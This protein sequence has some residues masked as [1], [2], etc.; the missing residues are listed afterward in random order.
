MNVSTRATPATAADIAGEVLI[1]LGEWS[2]KYT[3]LVRQKLEKSARGGVAEA[4]PLPFFF[5]FE[6]KDQ[7]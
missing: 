2:A 6:H 7:K 4:E 5:H 1:V 3:F